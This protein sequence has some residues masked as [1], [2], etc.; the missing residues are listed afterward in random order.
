MIM[1]YGEFYLARMLAQLSQLPADVI[2]LIVRHVDLR[3]RLQG[4]LAFRRRRAMPGYY[5]TFGHVPPINRTTRRLS[6][7]QEFADRYNVNPNK[8]FYGPGY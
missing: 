6:V 7:S 5:N 1:T 8:P 2:R 4:K 3:G